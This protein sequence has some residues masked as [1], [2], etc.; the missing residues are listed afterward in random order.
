[1]VLAPGWE[2]SIGNLGW[3]CLARVP[4]RVYPATGTTITVAREHMPPADMK[5][6]NCPRSTPGG[7]VCLNR[8]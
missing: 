8:L 5:R 1:M 4:E 6:K 2:R 3:N 7:I